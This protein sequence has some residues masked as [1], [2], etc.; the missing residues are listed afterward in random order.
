MHVGWVGGD[1]SLGEREG[2]GWM[3]VERGQ[4][5]CGML[6]ECEW[7]PTAKLDA[8]SER[9]L[10]R[11]E[12]GERMGAAEIWFWRQRLRHGRGTHPETSRDRHPRRAS[13]RC[14][15]LTD[16]CCRQTRTPSLNRRKRC[17]AELPGEWCLR[18]SCRWRH[19]GENKGD[20]KKLRRQ[21][22]E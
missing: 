8:V 22:L 9:V 13:E 16:P 3:Q 21:R 5:R 7:A 6:V 1:E 2:A 14:R 18:G 19:D 17:L 12:N 11:R 10:K 20:D 4:E 15:T